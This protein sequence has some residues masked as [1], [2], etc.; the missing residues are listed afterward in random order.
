MHA[1][2]NRLERI[3]GRRVSS[4]RALKVVE[5]RR[6][7]EGLAARRNAGALGSGTS[8]DQREEET[9]IDRL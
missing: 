9:W 3:M 4:L 5:A 8:W 2:L 6:L 7:A 1:E